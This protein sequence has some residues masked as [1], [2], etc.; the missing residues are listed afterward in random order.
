VSKVEMNVHK[1]KSKQARKHTVCFDVEE[2]L[3]VSV[4]AATSMSNVCS[5][6]QQ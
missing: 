6:A 1:Q 5:E 2:K 4:R 3:N